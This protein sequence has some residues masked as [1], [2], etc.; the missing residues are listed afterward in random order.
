MGLATLV[1]R[2][3]GFVRDGLI[4]AFYG[5]SLT[6][7]AFVVAFR[8]PNL[9]RDLV[10]EGAANS[11][12]VPVLSRVQARGGPSEWA[13]LAEA[14]W[15]RW[16]IGFVAISA[17]GV[18]LAPWIVQGVAPGFRSDP[19]LLHLTVRL[20]RILFPF[21]GLV[22]GSAFF[23]G[24]LNSVHHFA[25]PSLGPA[26]LNLCMIL[27]VLLWRPDAT[28]LAWG[29]IAGGI[30][31]MAIQV[32]LLRRVGVRLRFVWR[33]HPGIEEIRRLL[34][35]RAIGT[36][37]YQ[38]SVLIDTIFASFSQLVGP[39]GVACLYF[40]NRFLQLPLA[41][42]G[43]SMAQAALPTLSNQAAAEDVPAVR[44]T[45]LTALK[46]SL[47]VAIPSAVGLIVLGQPILSTLLERGAFS[48]HSTE[49]TVSALRGYA[50]GLGSFCAVKVLANVLF[51]FH[52]TWTPVRSAG[53]ALGLN[54]LLNALLIGPLRLAGLALA[55]SL[56][57]TWNA[58]NLYQA[59]RRRIGPMGQ[60]LRRWL[61]RVL[62]ASLAMALVSWTVWASGARWAAPSGF[63][64]ELALLLGSVGAGIVS[65]F[66]FASWL[67]I[68]EVLRLRTWLWR[69]N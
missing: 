39:G 20:T 35:P 33:Y 27:G 43:V 9:L 12:F 62:A 59:V 57:S 34:I 13:A 67:R 47:L 46:S 52:D 15:A 26:V 45:C 42:F 63:L 31:Q 3:L 53:T 69:R 21:I 4:A 7:Q 40:A 5:T 10:G 60:E 50:L 25:L 44:G 41:L 54:L 24:L 23:M 51:A 17:A 14:I 61:G 55:T 64:Q 28:G 49:T 66:A 58:W 48:A 32:P 1:S 36:A 38:G 6:A 16:A 18:L 68:E 19:E 56:S 2:L 29:V 65:F 30:L 37:V 22:A 8:V 11:A